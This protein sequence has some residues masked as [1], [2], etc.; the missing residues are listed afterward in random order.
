ML[1]IAFF[2][3]LVIPD[4]SENANTQIPEFQNQP[5]FSENFAI[6][7][8]IQANSQRFS[9]LIGENTISDFLTL[10]SNQVKFSADSCFFTKKSGEKSFVLFPEFVLQID[11]ASVFS[12]KT[13]QK[14]GKFYEIHHQQIRFFD[15]K[16][17]KII[18]KSVSEIK[19]QFLEQNLVQFN[20]L[21]G[22]D[23]FGRDIFSR[24][25]L[26]T[27]VSLSVGFFSVLVSIVIG[28]VL[29]LFSAYY[30]GR[31]DTF[32]MWLASVFWSIPSLLLAVIIAFVL[33]KGFWQLFLAIGLS[34]WVDIYR[35]MRTQVLKEKEE[36]YVKAAKM[37]GFSDFRVLF[38][39]I[40]PN[41]LD[42]LIIISL[43]NFA[44]AVLLEAGL[45]FLGLGIQI[46]TP[47]WGNMIHDGFQYII[48]QN[49]KLL[50]F[51]PGLAI[52][53][54]VLAVNYL[55]LALREVLDPKMN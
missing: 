1:F 29:G 15:K 53:S 36:N 34:I 51:A 52:V 3:Y 44:T 8:N 27:R 33:G 19:T 39:H 10:N 47:S 14:S 28:L 37:L 41:L 24:L 38:I 55:G 17:S 20:Y 45:S 40:L 16:Q 6:K 42:N 31:V 5:A 43:T 2:A 32:L 7:K 50:A 26:G 54:L 12:R 25:L 22:S 11:T 21:L 35:L 18:E 13:F 30:G 49:G 46:P 9:F 4:R 23:Q 48:F